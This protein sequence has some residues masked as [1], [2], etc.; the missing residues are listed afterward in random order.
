LFTSGNGRSTGIVTS[1]A[2]YRIPISAAF[3]N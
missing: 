2:T 3:T 1:T